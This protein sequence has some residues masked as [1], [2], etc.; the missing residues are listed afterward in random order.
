MNVRSSRY[1]R[2]APALVEH[3]QAFRHPVMLQ[4]ASVRP[5]A[6]HAH[7]ARLVDLSIY[8]CRIAL[9]VRLEVNDR[10]W[11]SFEGSHPIPAA[12]VWCD[13]SNAGCKFDAP[14]DRALF[15]ALTLIS[16]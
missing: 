10:I 1:R 2:V 11:L 15:R 3:R 8:G 4:R 14:I 9:D 16:E 5:H 13:G 6:S 7:D 12:V